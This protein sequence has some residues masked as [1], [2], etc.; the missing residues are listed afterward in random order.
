MSDA[1]FVA[2]VGEPDFH[3]GSILALERQ[4]G[5]LRVRV[6]G[7]SGKVFVLTFRGVSAVHAHSPEGMMLYALAQ[8]R[9][10]PALHHFVFVNWDDESKA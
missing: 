2:Y 4:D 6:R 9:G 8:L 5:T 7:A 10:E 1:S 3:D